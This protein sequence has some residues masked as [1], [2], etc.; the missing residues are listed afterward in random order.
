[1]E[2]KRVLA[3]RYELIR[4]IGSGGMAVV[5]QAYDTALDRQV[6]VKLLRDEYVDDPD[7]IRRFQKEAQAVARLSHQNIVNIYD[8]KESDGL[9]YLLMEYVEGSTLKDIIA[10][11]GPLPISQVIDYSVQLCY[12]LA[13]AHDQQLVHKDIKPHNI[14][15]DRNHVVKITDFGIA[16]AMNNLTIT[17]NKGILGS[18]H[19]FSPEQARGEHVDFKSDIYSLGVVMYEMVS[20]HVPF[21][22][23][24]PVTVALKHM[25]EAPPSLMEQRADVPLGLERI[26]F[27]ALEKNPAYRFRSM[28]EMA[29]ALL[30]LRLYLEEQGYFQSEAVL[31]ASEKEYVREYPK[32]AEDEKNERDRHHGGKAEQDNHTRVMKHGYLETE[33]QKEPSRRVNSKHVLILVLAAVALFCGTFWAV[34]SFMSRDEVV[35]PD[36]RDK[37]L[38]EAEQLLSDNSLKIVVEDEIFDGEIE[39]DHIISQLP[40]AES[41]VKEGREVTVV[42]SLGPDEV[43]VP[44]LQGKT[45]QE[46]RIALENEGLELGEV[47][48]VTDSSQPEDVVVYQSVEAGTTVTAGSK[49]DVMINEKAAEP[50]VVNTS[51]P[52]LVGKT[53]DEAR[54]AL[55]NAKLSE[56][57]VSQGS[58]NEYYS[59]YVSVQQTAAGSTVP[60]GS[61]VNYTV[62]T[63]PGPERS[64]QFE[65]IIPEDGTVVVTLQDKNG[66]AVLYQ[67][68]CVAGER[69]Q[70]SFL[71][72][73]SGTV[74]ITCNDKE[75]WSK[76][77]DG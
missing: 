45:E 41:K 54:K 1:M 68:D 16:Q 20:G 58:S 40:R 38:L 52:N 19:Y 56:G 63:G 43:Q 15:I 11:S 6:A 72:H 21:T 69:V 65:L 9:T 27:R 13:Q 37:T 57:T 26:I 25:Q 35:V 59:G 44:V 77:Y 76:E 22:G 29:D 60:E 5:Y 55:A 73:G 49:V 18:A 24:N 30:D 47:K 75:I 31:T 14:M 64:A 4:K 62:S 71:Y 39:K 66:S 67:K 23:E 28:Q 17:H 7:F 46:A 51:V 34:Q 42:I 32:K 8:F 61:K 3:N 50:A 70:Q 2:A 33:S 74:R 36:L 12:G 48:K 10:Q 53:Q